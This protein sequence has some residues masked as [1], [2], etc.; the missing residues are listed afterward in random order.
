ML[1]ISICPIV[2]LYTVIL[3]LESVRLDW[4]REILNTFLDSRTV[5]CNNIG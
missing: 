4:S 1:I 3:G 5:N 2:V